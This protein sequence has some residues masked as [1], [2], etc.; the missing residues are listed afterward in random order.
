MRI[1][2]I[3]L[4]FSSFLM[5]SKILSYNV[6]E[7][8][9][10]VDMMLTFDVPNDAIIRQVRQSDRIIL[11]LSD[12]TIDAP[13]IKKVN[14]AFVSKLTITPMNDHVQII[15]KVPSSVGMRAS[16]TP[17]AYGL[18][19]RF[20]EQGAASTTTTL[21]TQE[22]SQP[23]LPTKPDT[24]LSYSYYVV[25][26]ILVIGILIML[27]LKRSIAAKGS[28]RNAKPSIF[29]K[30]DIPSEDVSVRFQKALDPQNRVVML[31]FADESYLMVI[32]NSNVLLDKFNENSPRTQNEFEDMLQ[33]KHQELD[34]F[35]KIQSESE[36]LR[37]YKE[38]ASGLDFDDIDR[39]PR[40]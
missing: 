5:A 13:K 22:A 37:S 39:Q 25:V 7:R 4:L 36:A 3:T 24:E 18:R 12:T 14:S 20:F 6:Y 10:R 26:A 9:D 40:H 28:V 17:D 27:W 32:G 11:K 21:P 35:L 29:G 38:K 1:L 2:L 15:A 23:G 19:L 16:K 8:T 31:D 33:D 30:S 34:S